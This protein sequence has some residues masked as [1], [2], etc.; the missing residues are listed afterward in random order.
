MKDSERIVIETVV[1][2]DGV[3]MRGMLRVS[4]VERKDALVKI[5]TTEFA[6]RQK[7]I[8]ALAPFIRSHL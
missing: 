6:A 2:L 5:E 4:P 1:G 3:Y 8:E 7:I